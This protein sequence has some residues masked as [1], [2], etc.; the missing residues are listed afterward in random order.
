[1]NKDPRIDKTLKEINNAFLRLAK[2]KALNKITVKEICEEAHISRSTFYD[3][4][5]DYPSFLKQSKHY[6]L[7]KYLSLV[8]NYKFDT[9][10][11]SCLDA[12]INFLIENNDIAFLLF[13]DKELTQQ[14]IS[15]T[16]EKTLPLW[17]NES[18]LNLVEIDFIF[19]Y[20][21][22]G[23]IAAINFWI[24]HQNEMDKNVFKAIL[25][26]TVKYGVYNYIYTI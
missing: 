22:N 23:A 25:D 2:S 7:N 18:N 19:T 26:Q 9:D 17:A 5:E 21:I 1:M 14:V 24:N 15:A 4:F 10:T 3:H 13:N 8:S 11:S 20:F 16:K 12:L 6:F